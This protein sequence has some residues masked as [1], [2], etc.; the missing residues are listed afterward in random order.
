MHKFSLAAFAAAAL[1]A[2][3]HTS[4]LA[5]GD[6]AAGEQVFKKCAAC[7]S[8][9]QGKNKTGPSLHAVVGRPAGS[10]DFKRYKGLQGADFVWDEVLLDEYLAD[11]KKFVRAHTSNKTTAMSF[12]LK[13]AEDRANVI[14]YL[15][16][17]E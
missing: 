2:L 4:A 5:A 15:I 17:V 3:A 12:K 6:A 10:T 1:T 13:D 14:A 16:T 7:H 8:I 11:P 9:E